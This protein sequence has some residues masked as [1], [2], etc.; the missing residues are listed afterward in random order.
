M[1]TFIER[2][3]KQ[4][5]YRQLSRQYVH[6]YAFIG[7]GNHSLNNLYPVLDFMGVPLKYIVTASEKT[8][9]IL[10]KSAKEYTAVND[11]GIVLKDETVKG[12]FISAS[13]GSHY[14]LVTQALQGRKSVFVEKPPCRNT[15]E[16]DALIRLEKE[17]GGIVVA[18]MQKRYAP[19]CTILK[20]RLKRPEHYSYKFCTGA[21]PEGED[22]I[23]ELFIHPVDLI[24]YLFG[25]AR[26]VSMIQTG[27][28]IL[29]QL[30]HDNGVIGALELS[31]SYSWQTAEE[32]MVIV[33]KSGIYELNNM[34]ELLYKKKPLVIGNIPVEKVKKYTP[35]T[36]VLFNQNMFQPV[37][38]HN[39]IYINGF[40]SELDTFVSLC[41]HPASNQNLSGPSLLSPT[42]QLLDEI[43]KKRKA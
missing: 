39:N 26:L 5:K 29:L 27:K 42:Y 3:K 16:L 13:P 19:A 21:Y 7:V 10:N 23:T 25:Q 22:V 35:V 12:I 34:S 36:E 37:M 9:E 1:K 43:R 6:K 32:R 28:T 33:E 38:Q 17:T 30:L 31:T 14:T 24:V 11:P 2:Y 20:K 15:A 18:G 40:Y 8:A 4:R 41:E